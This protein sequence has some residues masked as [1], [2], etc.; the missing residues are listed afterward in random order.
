MKHA[1]LA[2]GGL[3]LAGL[4]A[5]IA[6]GILAHQPF[7]VELGQMKIALGQRERAV[8]APAGSIP[9]TLSP[10]NAVIERSVPGSSIR[11]QD[12]PTAE[13][14]LD[15]L[16]SYDV[17]GLPF[18]VE[19]RAI[20][21][22]GDS[23]SVYH[24][25]LDGPDKTQRFAAI[26]GATFPLKTGK[27]LAVKAI[28]P[29]QGLLR[30]PAGKP[31]VSLSVRSAGNEEKRFF[32]RAD[33][34]A[35]AASEASVYFQWTGSE[36]EAGEAVRRPATASEARWGIVDGEVV[37]WFYS[38]VPGTGLSLRDGASI[39]LFDVTRRDDGAPESIR[40]QRTQGHMSEI[41]T[42]GTESSSGTIRLESPP[43]CP[44]R[45]EVAA[46]REGSAIAAIY[47]LEQ[48]VHTATLHEGEAWTAQDDT[49]SI[50]LHRVLSCAVPIGLSAI[51][52]IVLESEGR[53][54]LVREGERIRIDDVLVQFE[55][56]SDP[57]RV[58]YTLGLLDAAG[59]TLRTLEIPPDGKVSYREWIF[60]QD[61]FD[62]MHPDTASL[63][64]GLRTA[65][66][67]PYLLGVSS[68]VCFGG[69]W[70]MGR[71]RFRSFRHRTA[72]DP[73]RT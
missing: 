22:L 36:E 64:I 57:P 65:S 69:A 18:L 12:G 20:K 48:L 44:V 47:R 59:R 4:V 14:W 56:L 49:V 3:I 53:E 70:V 26:P 29:W 8:A 60:S 50:R 55:K 63:H 9:E 66:S 71:A 31:M 33:E 39:S 38:F 23:R 72:L 68:A 5:A 37:N 41:L 6:G 7:S 43:P 21:M 30:D 40:V 42:A 32:V 34:S 27:R 19:T 10:K 45:V 17:A 51:D 35:I 54:W 13:R 1:S 73:T 67:L 11:F 25:A 2:A 52:E 24:V 15:P 62:A 61:R 28:R 16:A 58:Q 46:W